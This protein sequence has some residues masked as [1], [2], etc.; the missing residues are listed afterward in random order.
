GHALNNTLQDILIRWHKMRGFATL[1]APG[2]DHGGI[3]TQNVVERL[4]KK[5]GKTRQDLGRKKFLERMWEWRQQSGD[6]ILHQLRKLGCACDWTRTRFTMDE[7]SSRA[8]TTAFVKLYQKDLIYRGYRLVNWCV[9]CGTS[10]SDIEVEHE[11]T[12]GK[13]WHI[14]YP[15]KDDP[16]QGIVV[17]TTRP[18]TML[19]DTA[20]AVNPEDARYASLVGKRL[21]LPLRR[22][23]DSNVEIPLIADAAVDPSF[24]TG[25]VKV[26]PSHDAA[27]FEIA[28]RH[29]LPHLMVIGYEGRMTE[30][31]GPAYAGQTVKDCRHNVLTDL[32]SGGFLVKE[33]DYKLSAATCYRCGSVIE[34]LE[35]SQWFL[36][37]Q[38]MAERAARATEEDRV[39]IF[40]ESWEKPYLN[41]LH[42]NRDWCLSRQIWWGH[43]LPVWY[44]LGC[45]RFDHEQR[46]V[47][48]VDP[49]FKS[50]STKLLLRERGEPIVQENAPNAC[51]RCG[52][53]NLMRD[54]D[55]L[56][57]WFSS[58]LWPLTTLGWPEKTPDLDYFYPTSTLVTGH[59]ILYL[60]VARMVMMGLEFQG[61]VPYRHVFI[62]GI[63]RDKQGRKMS[64]SLNNVID[65]LDIM[66]KYGTDALRF[67]LTASA[68]PGRDM[69]LADDSFVGARNFANKIWNASRF[70]LM[71]LEGFR[72]AEAPLA[73][74]D[75]ADRWIRR[76][77]AETVR[78]AGEHI[79]RYDMAQA[80]RALYAFFWGDFCDWYIELSKIRLMKSE[81]D[82]P[83]DFEHK[84]TQARQTLM[85]VLDGA[86]RALHPIM[87]FI[88]EH[89]WQS[90]CETT[91]RKPAPS[92]MAAPGESLPDEPTAADEDMRAMALLMETVTALRTVRS[93]MNVPPGKKIAVNAHLGSSSTFTKK[94][95]TSYA[96][97]VKHLA[98][99]SELH[100]LEKKE[101]PP[102]SAAAVAGD[103]EMF[104]PLEGLIDFGKEKLRLQKEIDLLDT[105]LKRLD[106]RL[107]NPDFLNRAPKEEVEK[108]RARHA[109]VL[110]KRKRLED[111][112]AALS[113]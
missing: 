3:A 45:G 88:T 56:D 29:D 49:Y 28:Q 17:A 59:E 71:N 20:V 99:V 67:A 62:H 91:G 66:K 12:G 7:A 53:H 48:A 2:T 78:E 79:R 22:P 39:Q 35:S 52:S 4:L 41:W 65:P 106:S 103:F 19:G 75:L 10:L 25:A 82:L 33:E 113:N 60:W 9:R 36:K 16:S 98:K 31:A 74:R 110:S 15:F 109:E 24:G 73:D 112:I 23:E 46:N 51:P 68:V 111:H 108:A 1:W 86:L 44:C 8:V 5:E 30:K 90:L 50:E 84:R 77:L 18:E 101:K 87:P 81:G 83:A 6:T 27:D 11:E 100:L 55:V 89:L 47:L 13:L 43:Q 96:P 32:T 57:T 80:A 69:Q 70:A 14:R 54:P 63:V 64:K 97:Y 38:D 40:P 105:D 72:P 58:G 107:G 37:T 61:N 94:L 42:N 93:E 76:R 85:E 21:L 95:L 102:Q 104:V 92:L 26:T 34:P